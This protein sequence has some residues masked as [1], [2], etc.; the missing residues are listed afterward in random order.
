[1]TVK[2]KLPAHG[3][4]GLWAGKNKN[5]VYKKVLEKYNV[6]NKAKIHAEFMYLDCGFTIYDVE[7][8]LPKKDV[9]R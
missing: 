4:L 5:D 2:L 9:K 7:V 8:T 3:H 6:P 1:M